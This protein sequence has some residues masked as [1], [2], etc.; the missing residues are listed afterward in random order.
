MLPYIKRMKGNRVLKRNEVLMSAKFHV[1]DNLSAHAWKPT[2][3]KWSAYRT[4]RQLCHK[5]AVAD[6]LLGA[7]LL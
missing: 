5:V 7:N 4:E 2:Q 3:S 6:A 1:M